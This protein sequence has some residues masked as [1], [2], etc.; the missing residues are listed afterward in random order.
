MARHIS[1]S[2]REEYIQAGQSYSSSSEA[3]PSNK[4]KEISFSDFDTPSA[5]IAKSRFLAFNRA[6]IPCTLSL[7]QRVIVIIHF[8]AS[9]AVVDGT[10]VLD[11]VQHEINIHV[12]S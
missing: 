11:I 9:D 12:F 10:R 6:S 4:R 8:D 5:K 7:L 3:T 2:F 1:A